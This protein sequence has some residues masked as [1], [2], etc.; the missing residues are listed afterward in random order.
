LGQLLGGAPASD[1]Q[2]V[3]TVVEALF[4]TLEDLVD[5]VVLGH[6]GVSS[7][8]CVGATRRLG[9]T[10]DH[11]NTLPTRRCICL[12]ATQYKILGP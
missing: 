9:A 7:G 1:H 11:R 10:C 2:V 5:G 4:E 12:G 6:G 8:S 3:D